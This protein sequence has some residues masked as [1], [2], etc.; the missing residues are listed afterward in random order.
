[1]RVQITNKSS[2]NESSS[3]MRI[4]G[5]TDT[6]RSQQSLD[7]DGTLTL[8]IGDEGDVTFEVTGEIVAVPAELT[9]TSVA[10]Q[11]TEKAKECGEG[12]GRIIVKKGDR[13]L[14]I[15]DVEV[16]GNSTVGISLGSVGG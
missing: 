10:V 12:S 13:Q 1:M 9:A 8:A 2:N 4:S 15:T 5:R 3:S 16:G 11:P 7:T 14:L 6:P